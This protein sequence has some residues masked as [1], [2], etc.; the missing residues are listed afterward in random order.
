MKI[1]GGCHCGHITYEAEVD[2]ECVF[3]CHCTDCQVISGT[4]YRTVARVDE[5]DFRL[6]S[7][8]LK[9]YVKIADSGRERAQMFCPHCGSHIYATDTGDGPKTFGIRIG[10]SQ[11]RGELHPKSQYWCGSALDWAHDI[12]GLKTVAS[13]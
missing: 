6:L 4:A 2:P 1:D 11:Q 8:E 13:Q 5:S 7:G 3:L 10:T 12:S 9:A